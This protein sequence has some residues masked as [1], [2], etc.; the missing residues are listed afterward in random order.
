MGCDGTELER[1]LRGIVSLSL[2]FFSLSLFFF[3]YPFSS[4][5]LATLSLEREMRIVVSSATD[6]RVATFPIGGRST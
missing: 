3:L 4:F 1:S 6:E 2:L 5:S